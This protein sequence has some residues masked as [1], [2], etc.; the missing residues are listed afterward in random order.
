MADGREHPDLLRRRTAARRARRRR[1]AG[2][3]RR[4][5]RRRWLRPLLF[6]LLPVALAG[7]RLRIR[8]RRPVMSTDN[9]YVQADMVGVSTD[10]SGIVRD[11]R[12]ARQPGGQGGRRAVP[13]RRPAVP[14]RARRAPRRRSA[15][16]RP[17]LEAL[18]ASYRD[19]QAQIDQAQADID[20]YDTEVRAAAAAGR[21]RRRVAGDARPGARATSPIGAAEAGVAAGSSSPASSPTRPAIP[22]SPS[23]DHP[24][25]CRRGRGARR[26][27]APAR[28]HRRCGRRSTAS[29]PTCRSLQPGQYLRGR[30]AGVQ[31][32]LRPTTCGSRRTPRRPSSPM[33][34]PASR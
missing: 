21:Q 1:R 6:A 9:A 2:P 30:G 5:P 26:G 27:G 4:A 28:P 34:G 18:K 10:V 24:R 25:Y 19:M 20:F 3:R 31:P 23:S 33:C 15:S 11:D 12:G 8:D 17:S 14:P 16:C 22:T 32:R 7:G 29:S 13:A